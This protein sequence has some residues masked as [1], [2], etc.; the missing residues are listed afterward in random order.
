MVS[1]LVRKADNRYK[2]IFKEVLSPVEV[3]VDINYNF[4]LLH[5]QSEGEELTNLTWRSGK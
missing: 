3:Q 2:T 4:G 1:N 5:W